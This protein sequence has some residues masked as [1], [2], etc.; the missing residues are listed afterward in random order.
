MYTYQFIQFTNKLHHVTVTH[1]DICRYILA[2][3]HTYFLFEGCCM[4]LADEYYEIHYEMLEGHK[5]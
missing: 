1:M 2:S 5:S 3:R 4:L